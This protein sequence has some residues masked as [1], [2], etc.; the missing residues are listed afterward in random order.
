MVRSRIGSVEG[1]LRASEAFEVQG[2]D[3]IVAGQQ[4]RRAVP[5]VGRAGE[6]V[7]KQERRTLPPLF[8]VETNG[9]GARRGHGDRVGAIRPN[10]NGS[11]RR[12]SNA[13]G[14]KIGR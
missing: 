12:R 2:N 6:T 14:K 1:L 11:G 9:S 3:S 10:F 8:G 5:T 7:Q 4:R 13:D